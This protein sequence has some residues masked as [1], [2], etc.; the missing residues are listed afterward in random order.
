MLPVSKNDHLERL[1]E[2]LNRVWKVRSKRVA[3]SVTCAVLVMMVMFRF[4][5][6]KYH[7][8][9]LFRLGTLFASNA[10]VEDG[11]IDRMCFGRQIVVGH[12]TSRLSSINSA[13]EKPMMTNVKTIEVRSSSASDRVG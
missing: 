3:I 7:V 1:T 6:A 5:W 12:V 10:D 4:C 13:M 9:S 11:R 8:V 2:K